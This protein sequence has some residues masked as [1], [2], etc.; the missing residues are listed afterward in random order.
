[1]KVKRKTREPGSARIQYHPAPG[2]VNGSTRSRAF[3][4]LDFSTPHRS[5]GAPSP[6][7]CGVGPAPLSVRVAACLPDRGDT[8]VG[9]TP[10]RKQQR[11]ETTSKDR[12]P[13]TAAQIAREAAPSTPS[14]AGARRHAASLNP[15]TLV[16]LKL[17]FFVSRLKG[18]AN[19][20]APLGR[21]PA[22]PHSSAVRWLGNR[23]SKQE[24]LSRAT[25]QTTVLPSRGL[26]PRPSRWCGELPDNT[27]GPC[28]GESIPR[29]PR[30]PL[31]NGKSPVH[32]RQEGCL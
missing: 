24:S 17:A 15:R 13:R 9:G 16:V 27:R 8:T 26:P 20:L 30:I 23:K 32:N 7:N 22:E 25:P 3:P 5:E 14:A 21:G 1:M 18:C 10:R 2:R 19:R 29:D 6:A 12:F 31:D 11:Q 4:Q 28:G